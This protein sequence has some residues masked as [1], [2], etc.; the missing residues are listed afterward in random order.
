[1]QPES[2][3]TELSHDL[4]AVSSGLWRELA[5]KIQAAT[6]ADVRSSNCAVN[7]VVKLAKG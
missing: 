2:Q 5:G 1:M 6:C 7:C 3:E 4:T